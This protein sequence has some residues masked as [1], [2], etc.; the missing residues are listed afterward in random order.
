MLRTTNFFGNCRPC[1]FATRF[2]RVMSSGMITDYGG[3]MKYLFTFDLDG[4]CLS[5]LQVSIS[6]SDDMTR[7]DGQ[8]L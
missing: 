7:R 5:A 6:T 8:K 1:G 2:L 3:Q 4:K